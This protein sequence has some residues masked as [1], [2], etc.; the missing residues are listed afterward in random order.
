MI[1]IPEFDVELFCEIQLCIV[2]RESRCNDPLANRKLGNGSGVV[3]LWE[4]MR[5]V[6]TYEWYRLICLRVGVPMER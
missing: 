5:R 4:S 1:I 6:L 3:E 2:S